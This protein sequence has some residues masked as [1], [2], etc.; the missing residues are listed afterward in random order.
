MVLSCSLSVTNKINLTFKVN[1]SFFK[2]GKQEILGPPTYSIT[3]KNLLEAIPPA[4]LIVKMDIQ[5]FARSN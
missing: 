5:V 2:I 1:K 3:M 4:T